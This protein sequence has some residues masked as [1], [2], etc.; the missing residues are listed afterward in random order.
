M[1]PLIF[2]G[3]LLFA[4]PAF[5]QTSDVAELQA[6]IDAQT[7]EIEAL[8]AALAA[9]DAEIARLTADD[10][11]PAADGVVWRV[12]I[13]ETP[14]DPRAPLGAE[15]AQYAANDDVL[16]LGDAADAAE[17]PAA[18][19]TVRRESAFIATSEGF[20]GLGVEIAF[21]DIGVAGYLGGF[22]CEAAMTIDGRQAFRRTLRRP[23]GRS[24]ATADVTS[25]ERLAPGR[26]AVAQ[27]VAC[28]PDGR[29]GADAEP[30]LREVT[31]RSL[32]RRPSER[33]AQPA[34]AGDFAP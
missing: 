14:D 4:A 20:H 23:Y 27:Q 13:L 7:Q 24:A 28:R 26:Y 6:T 31:L 1:R 10:A 25:T 8:R 9:R 3:A 2:F 32:V 5:A 30:A 12:A 19:V 15:R 17:T 29:H 22:I 18:A 21:P 33:V 11:E 16:T 34:A